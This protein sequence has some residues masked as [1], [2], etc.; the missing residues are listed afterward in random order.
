[1]K[2]S[3]SLTCLIPAFSL[4]ASTST[5]SPYMSSPSR[6]RIMTTSEQIQSATLQTISKV[7]VVTLPGA[8]TF[9]CNYTG[10]PAP[11]ISIETPASS[12]RTN[13]NIATGAMK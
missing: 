13:L 3:L 1:M 10:D 6:S 11:T 2:L 5:D 4:L 7:A 12:N 8:I 9:V